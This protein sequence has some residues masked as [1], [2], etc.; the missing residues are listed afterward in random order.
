M[1]GRAPSER[2]TKAFWQR[3]R[4]LLPGLIIPVLILAAWYFYVDGS[5]LPSPSAVFYILLHPAEDI[6]SCGSLLWNIGVSLVRVLLGL[7]IAIVVGT[8]FGFM[9][10]ANTGFRKF[11]SVVTE[12][13]R[14]L[15]PI[16]LLP[17]S[18]I[19]F[20][21]TSFTEVLGLNSLKYT[22]HVLNELQIGMIFI[23]AWGGVFPII[24]ETMHGVRGVRKVYVEAARVLGASRTFIFRHVLLPASLPDIFTGYRMAVGR[25]WMVI[26]AAEMLPGTNSGIGYLLRYSYQLSRL[27]IMIA[28]ILIIAVIGFVFSRGLEY[29]GDR[30]LL[31]RARE[32]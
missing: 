20:K 6:L 13:A 2:N 23:L 21:D 4:D 32:R 25:C 8:P 14:P 12:L 1:D 30:W 22:R 27:D 3:I 7:F 11:T 16:A 18:I 29:A 31:L 10:G 24:L 26:I 17:L 19:V 28:C 15:S 9:M 5:F